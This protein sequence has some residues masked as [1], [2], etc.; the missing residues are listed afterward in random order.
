MKD[1]VCLQLG[2]MYEGG[3]K[4][5]I[6]PKDGKYVTVLLRLW[7]N[8]CTLGPFKFCLTA[9]QRAAFGG[10]GHYLVPLVMRS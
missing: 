1:V 8:L 6:L 7:L 9:P 10:R 4:I 3:G 2:F 5:S